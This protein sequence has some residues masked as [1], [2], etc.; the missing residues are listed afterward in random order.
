MPSC[1]KKALP[2]F[3]L[4]RAPKLSPGARGTVS[5]SPPLLLVPQLRTGTWNDIT[6]QH[7]HFKFSFSLPNT[8]LICSLL[9]LPGDPSLQSTLYWMRL[10]NA[11]SPKDFVT[12]SFSL[13]VQN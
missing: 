1:V 12:L 2:A 5:P 7:G 10:K 6:Q 4:G 9:A 11:P 8:F 3:V 13:C